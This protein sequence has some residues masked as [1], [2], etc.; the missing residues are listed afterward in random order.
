MF[1]VNGVKIGENCLPYIIAELSA[2]HG[3]DISRAKKSIK[4]AKDAGA[5][6]VKLQTYTPDTM[7]L[8]SKKEDFLIK[9][10]L[11]AGYSLYELYREACTPFE[12][13]KE[14]FDFARDIGITIF[15]SPFDETAIDLLEELKTPAYKIASFEITDLPLIKYAALKHKPMLISTG[16]ANL[17]EVEQAVNC[18]REQGNDKILLFHCIS[19]YPAKLSD[20]QLG[21]IPFLKE[22]YNLDVGLSDHTISNQAAV[23]ATALGASAIE[24]HFKLDNKDCGPDS[25][26]SILPSQL[27]RLI[28]E[29]NTAFNATRMK[30]LERPQSER[31]NSKYRRSIYFIKDLPKGH[32]ITQF[33]IKKV[34][35][36]YGLPPKFYE[37]II[38][39]TLNR[40]VEHAEPVSWDCFE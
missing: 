29:C 33:D 10:G 40:D 26:F 25:S 18:I 6:A 28:K 23:L 36:G 13:H 17:N 30:G 1:E 22:K 34:R 21:D 38:G 20:Y 39:K 3:G 4:A 27:K 14:L 31:N 5:S 32:I 9:E 37:L 19:S 35:P 12:W 15:S 24:K 8:N 16:L 7:T 2:N 11:W